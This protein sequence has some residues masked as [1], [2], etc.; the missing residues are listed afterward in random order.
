MKRR[1]VR[2]WKED[3]PCNILLCAS[4]T[5]DNTT[6][7]IILRSVREA[8]PVSSPGTSRPAAATPAGPNPS[9]HVKFLQRHG[10]ALGLGSSI[11]QLRCRTTIGSN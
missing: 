9:V 5:A 11:V 2:E 4:N 6:I 7:L 3:K 1:E 10:L 8:W